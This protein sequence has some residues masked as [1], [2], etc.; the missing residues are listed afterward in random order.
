MVFQL[1]I[2]NSVI[3]RNKGALIL[4]IVHN[5]YRSTHYWTRSDFLSQTF[6]II[7]VFIV[8][9]NNYCQIRLAAR[10]TSIYTVEVN[11]A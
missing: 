7:I 10:E 8:D 5:K 9:L 6:K 4:F 2:S 1:S 3:D 11:W